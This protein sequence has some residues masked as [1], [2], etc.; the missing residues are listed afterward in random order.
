MNRLLSSL[1]VLCISLAPV[2]AQEG[3]QIGIDEHLGSCIPMDATFYAEDGSVV[4]LG[5]LV[6]R[7]TVLALVYYNCPAICSPLLDGV[8]E[9]VDRSQLV[10]GEDY[11]IVTISFDINDTP[12]AATGEERER[13]ASTQLHKRKNYV[14]Q[15]TSKQVPLES[16]RFLT[17]DQESID[18]IVEAV[19]FR[20]KRDAGGMFLHS[21]ALTVLS[22][23]GKITRYLYGLTYLPFDLEM[24]TSEASE[25]KTGPTV[26]RLLRYCFAYDPQGKTYTISV[27]RISGVMILF[28]AGILL[29]YTL[30]SRRLGPS[31][32]SSSRKGK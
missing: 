20:Y 31:D 13:R 27:T 12:A 28:F 24:A 22:P 8:A 25:G 1:F 18:K 11:R 16:W 3:E 32:Y 21:G 19:G 5:D 4:R 17:G 10:P 26:N 23:E 14:A 6:D 9:V 15:V 29:L 30:I 2:L 7:P